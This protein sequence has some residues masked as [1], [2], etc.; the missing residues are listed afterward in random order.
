MVLTIR[1]RTLCFSLALGSWGKQTK[2]AKVKD[3][4]QMKFELVTAPSDVL[5]PS[6]PRVVAQ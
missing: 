6:A 4:K 5:T 2:Y 3:I 1:G